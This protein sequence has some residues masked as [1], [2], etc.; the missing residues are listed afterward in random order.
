[1]QP[2]GTLGLTTIPGALVGSLRQWPGH[3]SYAYR[4]SPDNLYSGLVP[5]TSV[6]T[7]QGS[8]PWLGLHPLTG[9]SQDLFL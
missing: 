3:V 5:V 4:L 2:G 1:M 7:L 6:W 8:Q 9:R